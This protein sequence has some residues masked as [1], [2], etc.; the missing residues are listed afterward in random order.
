VPQPQRSLLRRAAVLGAVSL[1]LPALASC[2]FD[3]NTNIVYTPAEG[4]FDRSAAVDVLGAAIVS[5]EGDGEG[6][7]VAGFSNPTSET[8]AVTGIGG[9][10]TAELAEPIEL[11]PEGF[12]Q[13][14]NE[15]GVP[16]TGDFEIGD[17]LQVEIA[18]STGQEVTFDVSVV[19]NAGYYEGIDGPIP[20]ERTEY[21]TEDLY[22]PADE[23]VPGESEGE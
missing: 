12:V 23:V 16:V 15:G 1:V 8:A 10:V 4:T 7:F 2:G 9:D 21:D 19:P 6:T 5:T 13:L 18:Y 17:F 11:A 22:T 14:A 3:E 20:T